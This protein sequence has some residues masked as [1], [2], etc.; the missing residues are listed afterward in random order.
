MGR[1]I[2]PW[3]QRDRVS[4]TR[5]PALEAAGQSQWDETSSP[6]G[7]GTES[8]GRD[9]RPWRQRDRVSG[10]WDETSGPEGSGTESVGR[11]I[12]PWR[13]RD[14]VSGTRHPAL[15][16]AGQSQRDE[17]RREWL[18]DDSVERSMDYRELLLRMTIKVIFTGEHYIALLVPMFCLHILI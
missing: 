9:I 15:E 12:R 16:A 18:M 3:R 2:R 6:E 11:D 17:T 8:V 4:G 13:Q 10:E 7:S 1:D 5:H 14:R